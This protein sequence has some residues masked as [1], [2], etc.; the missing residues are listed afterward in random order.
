MAKT[1]R[2]VIVYVCAFLILVKISPQIRH[3]TPEG[4]GIYFEGL[5]IPED[6][7]GRLLY[8]VIVK[9]SNNYVLFSVFVCLLQIKSVFLQRYKIVVTKITAI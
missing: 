6:R 7:K 8:G 4:K 3:G 1:A 5:A 9:N 2:F